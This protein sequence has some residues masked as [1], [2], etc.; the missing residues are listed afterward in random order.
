MVFLISELNA[1]IERTRREIQGLDLIADQSV[2]VIELTSHAFA[3]AYGGDPEA[4]SSVRARID[5]ALRRMRAH[6][7]RLPQLAPLDQGWR[8]IATGG[9]GAALDRHMLL[10]DNIRGGYEDIGIRYGLAADPDLAGF[11]LA[12]VLLAGIPERFMILGETTVLSDRVFQAGRPEPRDRMRLAVLAHRLKANQ[13]DINHAL[14][15]ALRHRPELRARLQA[16]RRSNHIATIRFVNFLLERVVYGA[17]GD[18]GG[19]GPRYAEFHT[20]VTAA[21]MRLNSLALP[22]FR[23]VL[24]ERLDEL[25]WKRWLT[26]TVTGVSAALILYL[27]VGF[28]WT[29]TGTV[30]R[31]KRVAAQFVSG[32]LRHRYDFP[33][34]DELAEVGVA[35]NRVGVA[36]L[37]AKQETD[38]ILRNVDEGLFLLGQ[39]N[40]IGRQYSA[41]TLELF[42]DQELAGANFLELLQG[43]VPDETIASARKYLRQMFQGRV[44]EDFLQELNPLLDVEVIDPES[45]RVRNLN[46]KFSRVVGEGRGRSRI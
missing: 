45:G 30:G 10:H 14:Q 18:F 8:E 7:E 31:L 33:A 32:E 28:Y 12:S 38:E 34:G 4:I 35:F 3:H 27:F 44:N 17:R 21:G 19:L 15:M 23:E 20:A 22:V 39:G 41:R 26:L 11:H 29:V 37:D 43:R 1:G 6:P 16:A 36:L 25:L 42:G 13:D 5:A 40:V 2:I 46:F 9:S 24:V